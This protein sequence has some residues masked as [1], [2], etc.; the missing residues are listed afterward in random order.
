MVL[1]TVGQSWSRYRR[2]FGSRKTIAQ[3]LKA[4]I[5]LGVESVPD[6]LAAGLLAGVNPLYGLNA[7][8]VG[9][10]FGAVATGS[11][12]MTVQATGA[13]AVIVAD[14]PEIHG[15]DAVGAMAMMTVMAGIAM[16]ALGMAGLGKLVRFIPAAVL[17]GFVNAVAV[18]IVLSQLANFTGFVSTSGNRLTRAVDTVLHIAQVS[19]LSILVGAVT[20]LLILVLERTRLGALSMVVGIVVGSALA[21]LLPHG[22]V[23]MISDVA[24]VERG[25]PR[26]SLP[27]P[28]MLLALI[29]PALSLALVGLVQGAGISGSIPNPDGRYPDASADFRGQGIA[30][31]ATGMLQGMPVGGSMSATA[32]ARAAGAKSASANLFAGIVMVSIVL[33]FAPL[34]GYIA[35]PALAGLLIIIGVRTFKTEQIIMVLKTGPVQIAVFLVT[36]ALTLLIP[37]QYAV[38]TGVGLAVVLHIARQ[39]NRVRMKRWVFDDDSG[40]PLETTPPETLGAGETVILTPYGSLFFASAD[41][42][43]QQL[44]T[45]ERDATDAFVILRLRGTD[46]LG[47]TFLTMLRAYAAEVRAAGATLMVAGIGPRVSAQLASTGVHRAI[48]EANLF[49]ERPRVGDAVHEAVAEVS[50]RRTQTG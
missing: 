38:L 27:D 17:I 7:Y 3:D 20:V 6:G 47:V 4:G 9:T 42:F 33:L 32:L 8:I 1:V 34:I 13:M 16:L 39:S 40:R 12:F 37:L 28:S 31:I 44:P 19:W 11:V 14:V 46:E 2:R 48:G 10:L 15:P 30:N 50:R 22:A 26:L 43:R 23:A 45:P 29:V 25:I 5:V 35:M 36:F 41:S 21:Q 24:E 49:L 18:N